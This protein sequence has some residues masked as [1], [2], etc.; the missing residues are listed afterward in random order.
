MHITF[1]MFQYIKCLI[2]GGALVR[3]IYSQTTNNG[4]P[5]HNS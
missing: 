5:E 2:G 3:Q 1:E 4:L